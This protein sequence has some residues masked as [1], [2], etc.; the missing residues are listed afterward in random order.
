VIRRVVEH[1]QLNGVGFS[2]AEFTLVTI[3]AVLLAAGYALHHQGLGVLITAGIGLNSLV[4]VAFG[5]VAWHRGE[6]GTPLAQVFSRSA[7]AALTREHPSLMADTLIVTAAVLV[8]FGLLTA[9]AA[10][11]AWN[12]H[13]S[14]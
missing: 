14:T 5:G 10:E 3:A 2:I 13:N 7:R 6:R 9:M 11:F 4:I 1:N 8:P 12:S